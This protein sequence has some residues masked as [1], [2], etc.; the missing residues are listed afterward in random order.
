[1]HEYVRQESFPCCM[2]FKANFSGILERFT[3]C[4]ILLNFQLSV[5]KILTKKSCTKSL[6][7]WPKHM[8]KKATNQSLQALD[9]D[10]VRL[11]L[12]HCKKSCKRAACRVAKGVRDIL[13][14]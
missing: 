6:P 11:R 12:A 8:D 7:T 5:S 3:S 13:V 14:T 4:E 2:A 10:G 9:A 1:M